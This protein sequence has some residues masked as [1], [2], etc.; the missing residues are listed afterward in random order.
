MPTLESGA[1][2]ELSS[3]SSGGNQYLECEATQNGEPLSGQRTDQLD[4]SPG[5]F[6][7]DLIPPRVDEATQGDEIEMRINESP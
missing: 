7:E 2:Q 1:S 5:T 3:N 6:I 4:Y